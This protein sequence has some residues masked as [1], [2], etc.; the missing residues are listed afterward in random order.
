MGTFGAKVRAVGLGVSYTSTGKGIRLT[1]L[2][3]SFSEEIL[4]LL[5]GKKK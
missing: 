3:R 4:Y 5:V 1:I 2:L